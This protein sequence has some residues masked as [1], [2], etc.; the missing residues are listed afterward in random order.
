MPSWRRVDRPSAVRAV[1]FANG[2]NP[3]SIV[4]P[5][6][7]VVGSDGGPTGYGGGID[8]KRWLLAHESAARGGAGRSRGA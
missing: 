4:V 2:A 6:H 3:I 1:G 8:R 7:R 5:R